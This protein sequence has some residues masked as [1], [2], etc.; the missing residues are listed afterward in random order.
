MFEALKGLVA[1]V[2]AWYD[3]KTPLDKLTYV[4]AAVGIAYVV[5]LVI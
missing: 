5:T 3:S 4:V 2:K 1:K